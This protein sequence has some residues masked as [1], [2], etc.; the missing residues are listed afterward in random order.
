MRAREGSSPGFSRLCDFQVQMSFESSCKV[1]ELAG[2]TSLTNSSSKCYIIQQ[3]REP[4]SLR[5]RQMSD[6]CTVAVWEQSVD[7]VTI[8]DDVHTERWPGSLNSVYDTRE[9]RRS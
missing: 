8:T 4:T 5:T 9:N 3:E 2:I 6:T 7:S 1:H